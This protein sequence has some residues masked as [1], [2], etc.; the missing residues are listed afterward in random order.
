MNY[1]SIK[2]GEIWKESLELVL[3]SRTA[4]GGDV[5]V[6]HT[7][8]ASLFSRVRVKERKKGLL[9]C[10]VA[11]VLLFGGLLTQVFSTKALLC[12]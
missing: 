5:F 8:I 1:Y 11:V 10:V 3:L 9:I 7:H 12:F 6:S 4:D 2:K